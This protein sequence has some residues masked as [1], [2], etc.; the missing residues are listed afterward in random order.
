M[1]KHT[2]KFLTLF[3]LTAT[4]LLS[5]NISAQNLNLNLDLGGDAHEMVLD[6]NRQTLYISVPAL[7]EVVLVSTV[8]YTIIDR[9][10]LPS[11]TRGMDMS[12]DGDRLFVALN[13]SGS[14]ANI[15]LNN[16]SFVTIDVSEELGDARAWDVEYVT[17]ERVFVSA[18]AGSSGFAY[19]VE[20]QLDIVN[21]AQRVAGGRIIRAAPT[22][23]ADED[24]LYVGEGFSPNS[25]YKLDLNLA[26]I[27]IV[28]EDVHGSI[29]GA[30]QL[31]LSP[32]GGRIHTTNGQVIDTATINQSAD[33]QPGL[34]DYLEN[35][36]EFYV[37]EFNQAGD[38]ETVTVVAQYDTTT[39]LTALSWDL[40]CPHSYNQRPTDFIALSANAGF[41]LLSQNMLCGLVAEGAALDADNDGIIDSSDNCPIDSNP[42]QENIDN[43]EFGD[44]CDPYPND[45]DNLTACLFDVD[46]QSQTILD[47]QAENLLLKE[48]LANL[49][50]SDGDGVPD[51]EDL[52]PGTR[53]KRNVDENGC[54]Q[55]QN[56]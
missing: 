7:H 52:C 42:D 2:P 51:G 50:D 41:L 27:P 35:D 53:P 36:T 43:D 49:Q 37:A 55:H 44:V 17:G 28:L 45:A 23:D 31:M 21:V 1:F 32:L 40:Q 46:D 11:S 9:L 13:D 25:I 14:V 18:N 24:Y 33:V 22:F 16:M 26:G 10:V 4:L 6:S 34:T 8:D 12:D 39:F 5:S 56:K 54:S 48:E 30:D 47:L 19:I 15:D 38:D 29:S 3:F 20:I